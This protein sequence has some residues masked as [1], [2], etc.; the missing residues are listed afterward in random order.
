MDK[1]TPQII[2]IPDKPRVPPSQQPT[3]N[4][5][6]S[7]IEPKHANTLVRR[8]NQIAPLENLR[9]VRRIRRRHLQV[10]GGSPELSVILC[11]ACENETQF[12]S[13]PPDVQEIVNSYNLCPFITKVSKYAALS[14]EE[15]DEQCKLWPTSYHPLTYN[16]DGIT[17]FSEEDTK[18]V[19]SFMK[20]AVELAKSGDGLV[21]NAAVIVDP[22]AGLIIA[23]ACDEVCSWHMPTNKVKTETC[24]FKQLETFTSHADANRIVRDI[25]M[26]SNGSS[27]N[28]QQCYT[29]VSCL[30]PWQWAQH[31]FHRSHCYWHPLRH[32]AIVAVEASAARDRHL[33]PGSGYNEK[34]YEVDCT[35]SSSSISTTKRQKIV[36]LANVING[37]EHDAHIEGSHSLA[38]PYLCTGY[39]IYLVWE[40][41]TMCAM[42]LV[43]QRIRRI[44]YAFPNPEAGALG[45]VHRLQGEKSL[46]HHYAVFRVVLPEEVIGRT[47]LKL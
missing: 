41:C 37:G 9:H 1:H 23:S 43:H 10:Q 34:L 5:Y 30:N 8:L 21:V 20:S 14:K 6:A 12:N 7:I 11:L 4:V 17:G 38:R 28:L 44:F 3:V 45:S 39:D 27:N 46:N 26:L 25:T 2:H 40:P 15:W 47:K 32:A 31:A 16:I 22:S 18:S 35:H 29:A 33:F 36:N 13:M 19:F 24:C 42:G